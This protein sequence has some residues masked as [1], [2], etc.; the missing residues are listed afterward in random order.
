VTDQ[1]ETTDIFEFSTTGDGFE[2]FALQSGQSNSQNVKAGTYTVTENSMANWSLSDITCSNDEAENSFTIGEGVV[3]INLGAGEEI[4]CTFTN[5]LTPDTVPP[6]SQFNENHS[7][8]IITTEIVS[9]DLSGVSSDEN[10]GVASAEMTIKKIG[11]HDSVEGFPSGSFHDYF[12]VISC[13]S[14]VPTVDI[15]IVALSLTSIEPITVT[16]EWSWVYN[17]TPS[18]L[19][20]SGIYCFEVR[21]TDHAGNVEETAIA[22]PIAYIPTAQVSNEE[23]SSVGETSFVANWITDIP[24]TSRVIYD[25]VSHPTLGEKQNYGYAFSTA[26][27]DTEPKVTNHSVTVSGLSAGTTYYYRV[28]SSASPDAVG[29]E[30]SI[31]TAQASAPAGGGSSSGG[32]GGGFSGGGSILQT[33][34]ATSSAQLQ[35]QNIQTPVLSGT[36]LVAQSNLNQGGFADEGTDE[37][38]QDETVPTEDDSS[39]DTSP[40]ETETLDTTPFSLAAIGN[41]LGDLGYWWILI[42]ILILGSAS[43]LY[44]RSRKSKE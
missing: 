19:D 28:I 9:L 16:P 35:S 42:I 26:V 43:Y 17:W 37:T 24:A 6:V 5:I 31:T 13:G 2:A 7:H 18:W 22:G 23:S 33:T 20:D 4:N 34:Q 27:F 38:S 32:G 29:E 15:E 21:A 39:F 41:F 1:E 30:K 40:S 10:S 8:K 25:T 3:N 11:D 14:E 36:G 12:E 44:F